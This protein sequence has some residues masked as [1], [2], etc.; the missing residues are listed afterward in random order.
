MN[1]VEIKDL[2]NSFSYAAFRAY[3]SDALQHNPDKLNL[4]A[5]YLPYAEL[6]EAR[7]H[8]LDKTLRVEPEVALVMENLGKEYIWLVISESW[9]GDAAQ[10]VPMLNK[11]AELTGKVELRLVFRD[12]N[13]ELM[14]Q[15]LTNGGRAIPKLLIV[16]KETLAVLG[17]WGPRPADAV[18]LVNDYK[19]EHGKFDED[20][21]I[22]LNKWYTKNKGQQVQQEVAALMTSIDI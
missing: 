14:D 13:L 20:G 3:V 15:Y 4:S 1:K 11:M 22:L 6:N 21:I 16:D 8:R 17:H 12:Q 10:S 19:T 2:N 5:D 7:L 9:C 18:Q